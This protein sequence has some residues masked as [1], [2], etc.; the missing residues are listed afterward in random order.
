MRI[1]L[2]LDDVLADFV[3]GALRAHGLPKRDPRPLG[4]WSLTDPLRMTDAEFWKPLHEA[5]EGFWLGLQPLPWARDLLNFVSSITDDWHIVSSPSNC[6]SSHTGKI[7]WLRRFIGPTFN[8]FVLTGD[9][10]LLAQGDVVLVD[11][12]ESTLRLFRSYHGMGCLFPTQGNR[13][14]KMAADPMKFV[15]LW[16]QQPEFDLSNVRSDACT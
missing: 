6:P 5:G 15:R 3:G 12:R 13:H 8:R 10:H 9:K 11:D 7:R 14:H 16:F 1:L 4:A 2:D